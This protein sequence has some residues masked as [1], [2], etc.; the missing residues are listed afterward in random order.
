MEHFPGSATKR[1]SDFNNKLYPH[2]TNRGKV[3]RLVQQLHS[4][5]SLVYRL[6]RVVD[7]S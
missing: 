3:R 7:R 5:A 6:R 1:Y 4:I 2:V